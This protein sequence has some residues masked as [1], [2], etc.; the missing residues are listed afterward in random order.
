M[1]LAEV[2]AKRSDL[3]E[4]ADGNPEAPDGSLEGSDREGWAAGRCTVS[5]HGFPRVAPIGIFLC[6]STF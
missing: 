2:D 6:E 3:D 4:A 1:L 5:K